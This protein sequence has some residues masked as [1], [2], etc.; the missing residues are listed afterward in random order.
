[1]GVDQESYKSNPFGPNRPAVS[2]ESP[3]RHYSQKALRTT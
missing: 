3:L 1:M 2:S